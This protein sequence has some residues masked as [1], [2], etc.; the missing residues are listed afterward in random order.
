MKQRQQALV[1]VLQ[2]VLLSIF[3]RSVAGQETLSS[4]QS[5]VFA[6]YDLNL[7]VPEDKLLAPIVETPL[8]IN[9]KGPLEQKIYD[10]FSLD[11]SQQESYD[12]NTFN[13]GS[14]EFGASRSPFYRS[15]ARIKGY[16]DLQ[17][18][19]GENGASLVADLRMY[20]E[21][22]RE[23]CDIFEQVFSSSESALE[24]AWQTSAIFRRSLKAG[25]GS[26]PSAYR[27]FIYRA[28]DE[29]LDDINSAYGDILITCLDRIVTKSTLPSF[30]AREGYII[31]T[32]RYLFSVFGLPVSSDYFVSTTGGLGTILPEGEIT[33][34]I[35]HLL[36]RSEIFAHYWDFKVSTGLFNRWDELLIAGFLER[37]GNGGRERQI[38]LVAEAIVELRER[39][40]VLNEVSS[41]S[42]HLRTAVQRSLGQVPVGNE[43]MV[44][45]GPYIVFE[46]IKT[47]CGA[48]NFSPQYV[49][50]MFLK[51]LNV[52][53]AILSGTFEGQFV[54]VATFG[55]R[56]TRQ[57]LIDVAAAALVRVGI[58]SSKFI[59]TVGCLMIVSS[60]NNPGGSLSASFPEEVF[61]NLV[62]R[63]LV[64]GGTLPL[65]IIMQSP[66]EFEC[67][68]APKTLALTWGFSRRLGTLEESFGSGVR[69]VG[70]STEFQSLFS[71]LDSDISDS[72]FSSVASMSY[73]EHINAIQDLI[74][75]SRKL[76]D[77]DAKAFN[78]AER[79][80]GRIREARR[81]AML[82]YESG[83]HWGHLSRHFIVPSFSGN[84]VA[85]SGE[86]LGGAAYLGTFTGSI[87]V[88]VNPSVFE[89][90][91]E[92]RIYKVAGVECLDF[93]KRR[94][95]MASLPDLLGQYRG[96]LCLGFRRVEVKPNGGY[97]SIYEFGSAVEVLKNVARI[98]CYSRHK[99]T[100]ALSFIQNP[101]QS[102][103]KCNIFM[104][105]KMYEN[106]IAQFEGVPVEILFS[107]RGELL[108]RGMAPPG[109]LGIGDPVRRAE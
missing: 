87:D 27:D 80:E 89:A 73:D 33:E 65:A 93:L 46:D 53:N 18:L 9:V 42:T 86:H 38:Q 51:D 59:D 8:W 35:E 83:L 39:L 3:V 15:L 71:E 13:V 78:L 41:V 81:E 60:A 77:L 85:R 37:A 88:G 44:G 48:F 103:R 108:N 14:I 4:Y 45:L 47:G 91:R 76:T 58:N 68:I 70:L 52:C 11:A 25:D 1:L 10:G 79:F 23:A 57:A 17:R 21:Y 82:L 34:Q 64:A 75:S 2:I 32:S 12:L 50:D 97:R 62:V 36:T 29:Y 31:D 107:S 90:E 6:P 102:E 105:M 61:L 66:V 74:Q 5:D 92:I 19:R 49:D 30:I 96:F 84:I 26:H 55:F 98:H 16:E 43:S 94:I 54:P 101:G 7:V 24:G 106:T 67:E 104:F 40:A 63:E 56:P 20:G 109:L 69:L 95:E 28:A 72:E 22:E 99:A 100:L